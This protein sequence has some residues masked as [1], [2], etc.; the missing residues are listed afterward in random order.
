MAEAL[1]NT[2]KLHKL[3]QQ[4][5][6]ALHAACEKLA[7]CADVNVPP[8]LSSPTDLV[9]AIES[10]AD[11]IEERFSNRQTEQKEA[12]RVREELEQVERM[13]TRF[14]RNVSHEMRTPLASIEGF[15][16]ALSRMDTEG[17]SA[18]TS[19]GE[20]LTPETRK[21]FLAIIS[22]EAQRL[23]KLIEDVLDLS[24][25]E[26]NHA[27]RPAAQFSARELFETVLESLQNPAKPLNVTLRLSPEPDGPMI[28]AD[29][30]A[31]VEVFRQLVVNAQKFSAGQEVVLGAELMSI[32]PAHESNAGISGVV[33][34][35]SSA[36][37]LYVRDR[38]IGI[39][40]EELDKIFQKFYR[41]ERPGFSVP[42]TGL[43][44]S[45]VR[46]LINQNNGQV[47]AESELGRGSTFYV[48]L[49]N[50][51]PGER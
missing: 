44:L 8:D 32:S 4:Q 28:Y 26:N 29:R 42:G 6:D 17:A 25:I 36:S 49:P 45:I 27:P 14:I 15:A 31:V 5:L 19:S 35:I 43:G 30:D 12:T 2:R 50:N 10:L 1:K 16:R 13:K 23:G 11:A 38:G 40:K 41:I 24:E 33:S 9:A 37:R 47:W 3:S 46:A 18:R 21:Q 22:Q 7:R 20:L 48:M 34:R 39:P 51:P